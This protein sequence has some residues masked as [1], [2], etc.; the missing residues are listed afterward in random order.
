MRA[1]GQPIAELP[2]ATVTADPWLGLRQHTAARI[3]LSRAGASLP[4][5]EAL[6]FTLAHA[7]ARDAVH[8]PLD[9]EVLS[10]RLTALGVACFT[11]H[12]RAT[13]RS[14]F[15]RR[16]DLGRQL[17]PD[18]RERVSAQATA[19]SDIA[20]VIADGLSSAAVQA[21][22][23]PFLGALLPRL[24][25]DGLTLSPIS[26]VLEGRVAIGDEIG[27]LLRARMVLVLIGERPGLSAAD[28]LGAYS[29]HD[30][31]PGRS[32]AER[33]CISNIR[34]EGLNS[35]AA[36]GVAHWL[37]VNTLKRQLSGVRLK[38]GSTLPSLI[39]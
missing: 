9:S 13:N 26:I 22:A 18:E 19:P 38:D 2:D 4:T 7:R 20:I 17:P 32:D 35:V 14:T 11:T 30:P 23:A 3:A 34:N 29:T 5:S 25:E 37:I 28:S 1:P 24:H 39:A 36:A 8:A 27:A 16:P 10:A 12:S 6:A 33:N 21:N 15:L 31:R